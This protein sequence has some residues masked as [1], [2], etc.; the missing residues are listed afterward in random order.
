[1]FTENAKQP[2]SRRD[3][4]VAVG[5]GVVAATGLILLPDLVSATEANVEKA[6]ADKLGGTVPKE[7]M[8]T[9]EVPEAAENGASVQF[10]VTVD[11]PMTDKDYVKE[12]H[13]FTEGNPTP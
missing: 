13:V 12:I 5:I 1:M 6:I 4:L 7:G 9:L 3:L 11:N 2:L 8:I 10:T